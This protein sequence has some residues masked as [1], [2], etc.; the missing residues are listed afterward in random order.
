VPDD[1]PVIGITTGRIAMADR[2]IDGTQHEYADRVTEA[3]G[4]AV[5]LPVRP[6]GSESPV[7]DLV[8]GLVFTGGGDVDPHRYGAEQAPESGG[9]DPERDETET[10]L[11][12][13]ARSRGL[14]VLAVC[15]GIQ[16][17]NVSRGG[18]LI[19]HLPTVTAEPHLVIER[20][21][22]AVH[23]VRIDPESSLRQILG[24]DRVATNSLHHQAI[25]RLGHHLVAVAWADDGIV[26]G[27]EDQ[28]AGVTGLQW[29]PEQMPDRPEQMR[30][31]SWLVERAADRRRSGHR[32]ARQ[33]SALG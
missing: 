19:Q 10:A 8:D 26:E 21:T 2:I 33:P 27:V 25:D 16:I 3:G 7:L 12:E 17:L 31:F 20:R 28:D 32:D 22:E 5:L 30:L 9:I 29:H 15:R 4:L 6:S 13:G 1:A 18:T 14:P 23:S 11:L 24:R